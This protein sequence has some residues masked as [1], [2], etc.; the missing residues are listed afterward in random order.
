MRE[1]RVIHGYN[2]EMDVKEPARLRL[3]SALVERLLFNNVITQAGANYLLRK[4]AI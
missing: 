4:E 2:Y 1:F 3:S